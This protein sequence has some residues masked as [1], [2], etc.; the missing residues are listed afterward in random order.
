M[1]ENNKRKAGPTKFAPG[2]SGN[3]N[4]RPKGV[5]NKSTTLLKDALIMAATNAGDGDMVNYLT[6]QARLNPQSFLPLLGK[7]LPLQV[8]GGGEAIV[9]HAIIGGDDKRHT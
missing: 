6:A 2:Q 7:V 4:G 1:S 5:P 8:T 3:P 9:I